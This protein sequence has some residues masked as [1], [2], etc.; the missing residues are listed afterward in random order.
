MGGRVAKG[1]EEGRV[2][3]GDAWGAADARANCPAGE[4]GIGTVAHATVAIE[5]TISKTGKRTTRIS[6]SSGIIVI[7]L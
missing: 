7:A 6:T 5:I 4:V 2:A 3:T 1:T